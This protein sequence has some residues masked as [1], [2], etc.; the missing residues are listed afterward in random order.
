MSYRQSIDMR[1]L[2]TVDPAAANKVA[3][4]AAAI[5]M[6]QAGAS[7]C[8]VS[9]MIRVRFGRSQPYAWRITSMAVDLAG[10]RGS[11]R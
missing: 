6:L 11:V 1:L 9:R 5:D 8:D 7:F 2:L 4:L 10:Q 3:H